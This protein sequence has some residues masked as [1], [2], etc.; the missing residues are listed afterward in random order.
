MTFV[1][2][3]KPDKPR[4]VEQD[5]ELSIAEFTDRVYENAPDHIELSLGGTENKVISLA[6]V[7]VF[8]PLFFCCLS[9]NLWDVFSSMHAM[10]FF[11]CNIDLS[12]YFP[13]KGI[14]LNHFVLVTHHDDV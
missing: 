8:T 14:H 13:K 12:F 1:D 11:L 4:V 5:S 10:S 2:K 6:K 9:L 3:T 7:F